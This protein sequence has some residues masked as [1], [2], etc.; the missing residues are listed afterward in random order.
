MLT[1]PFP[2]CWLPFS[3]ITGFD[4]TN[5]Q[6]GSLKSVAFDEDT[7]STATV[8]EQLWVFFTG[9]EGSRGGD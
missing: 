5:V 2:F 8:L 4:D 9:E 1:L 6:K 3:Q 7:F